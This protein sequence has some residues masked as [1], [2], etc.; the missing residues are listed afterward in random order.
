MFLIRDALKVF[1]AEQRRG[2]GHLMM[3]R[4]ATAAQACPACLPRSSNARFSFRLSTAP[5]TISR[6][7]RHSSAKPLPNST[8][9]LTPASGWGPENIV[10]VQGGRDGLQKA[11]GAMIALGT[12]EVGSA[13][14]VSRVPWISYN[15][16][17][18]AVGANV[19]LAPGDPEEGWRLTPEGIRSCAGIRCQRRA[20]DRRDRHHLAGQ[21]DRP[22]HPGRANR[23]SW[24]TP[25]SKQAIR[26]C[27]STGFTTG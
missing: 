25:R 27:C 9:S 12:D 20:Q 24:R 8:G 1:R 19:L 14:V 11:Y 21:P 17:P 7:A 4:R 5:P 18:Y 2:R 26:S 23:S 10:F 15:W 3:P 6:S 22:H 16:G 13:I